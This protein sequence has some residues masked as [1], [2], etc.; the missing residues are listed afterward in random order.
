MCVASLLSSI[1]WYFTSLKP[2][3]KRFFALKCCIIFLNLNNSFVFSGKFFDTVDETKAF[4]F[5]NDAYTPNL[6]NETKEKS[7]LEVT[8]VWTDGQSYQ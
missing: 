4:K 2:L 1:S 6:L 7:K 8:D 5:K 3:I